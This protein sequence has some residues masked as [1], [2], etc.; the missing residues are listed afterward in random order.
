MHLQSWGSGALWAPCG[1]AWVQS[2]SGRGADVEL[3]WCGAALVRICPGPAVWV[4]RLGWWVLGVV[5][6]IC[7]GALMLRMKV[8]RM[9]MLRVKW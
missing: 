5:L 9:K 4:G 6:V 3:V 1:L 2:R 8:L 7:R